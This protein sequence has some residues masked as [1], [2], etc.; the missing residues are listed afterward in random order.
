MTNDVCDRDGTGIQLGYLGPADALTDA[1][2]PWTELIG[3]GADSPTDSAGRNSAALWLNADG[4]RDGDEGGL[5][6]LPN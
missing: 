3:I 4:K 6:G 5:W 1:W 2:A